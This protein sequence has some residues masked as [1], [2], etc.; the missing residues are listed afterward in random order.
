MSKDNL[1][2]RLACVMYEIRP[3]YLREENERVL[4][5]GSN[6]YINDALREVWHSAFRDVLD[7]LDEI[8]G[9]R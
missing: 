5:P 3:P 8:E 2:W 9:E 7:I 1:R 6:T 4:L